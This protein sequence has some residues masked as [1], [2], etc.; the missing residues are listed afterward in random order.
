MENK[1]KT[2]NSNDINQELLHMLID[3][4]LQVEPGKVEFSQ[5]ETAKLLGRSPNFIRQTFHTKT[6]GKGVNIVS[7]AQYLMGEAV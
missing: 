2:T 6:A 4:I 7:I 3:A 5:E 1:L